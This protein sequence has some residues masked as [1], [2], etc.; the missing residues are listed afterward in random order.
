VRSFR[1]V[2]EIEGA[3]KVRSL[4]MAPGGNVIEMMKGMF[5]TVESFEMKGHEL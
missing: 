3:T 4:L 2:V 1:E 5:D